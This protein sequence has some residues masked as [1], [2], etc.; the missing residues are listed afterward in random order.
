[1]IFRFL[2]IFSFFFFSFNVNAQRSVNR[3]PV[4]AKV[5][6]QRLGNQV[7]TTASDFASARYGDRIYF[8]SMYR[9]TDDGSLV[10]RIYSFTNDSEATLVNDL[11]MN[12][13]SAHI[14][15]IAFMP[16]ASRVYFTICKDDDQGDC[17]IWFR[18]KEYEGNWGV[19]QKLPGIINQR[20]TTST[21][22]SIGW[23][24][25]QKKFALFFVSD[26]EG[27]R[28][29]KDIWVSHITW[30]GNFITPYSLPVNTAKD[31]VAPYFDR[32]SQVLFFSSNGM[33]GVGRFD[34]YQAE[35]LGDMW[36]PPTNLGRPY[37][38]AYDDL[39]Y[40]VH[41]NS[42]KAYFTSDRPGSFCN[43]GST[44]GWNCYD[45]YEVVENEAYEMYSTKLNDKNSTLVMGT[46]D[47]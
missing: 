9:K 43:G 14:A 35:K 33:K 8:T 19:A 7:N 1:M 21:Q 28:G 20:G 11:S 40:T 46:V 42:G 13:K 32:N 26:R 5:M 36:A 44:E 38:S 47:N 27:G 41:E 37:N 16:D 15:H 39:Y 2:L 25:E 6:V 30:D 23:D 18:D 45:I 22:P 17:Q 4:P 31:D 34:I 29:G 10:T 3:K 12:R 24:E